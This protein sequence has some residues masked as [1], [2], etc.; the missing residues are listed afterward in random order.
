NV[1]QVTFLKV[2]R[3]VERLAGG[4]IYIGNDVVSP[5]VPE[6]ADLHGTGFY[7]PVELDTLLSKWRE[8]DTVEVDDPYMIF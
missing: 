4:P 1:V 3:V 5:K 2:M 7:L 6:D 8:V